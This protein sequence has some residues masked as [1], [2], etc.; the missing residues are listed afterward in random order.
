[1]TVLRDAVEAAERLAG[2]LSDHRPAIRGQLMRRRA[3]LLEARVRLL[4]AWAGAEVDVQVGSD[5]E[6]GRRIHVS[7]EPGTTSAL[8]VADHAALDDDVRIH[9]KGGR[10][11]LDP[12]AHLRPGVVLNVSGRLHVGEQ[13]LLSWGSV[14]HCAHEVHIGRRAFIGEYTTIVD[15]SH[16]F[17]S[18]DEWAY[19][20]ISVGRVEIGENTWVAAK[21]TIARDVRIGAHCI[22]SASA[23]V[24]NDVPDGHLAAGVPAKARPIELPWGGT[25]PAP[26][27]RPVQPPSSSS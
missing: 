23:V 2:R 13:A 15:S 25:G 5:V 1:M 18:P 14:V 9:L 26:S 24:L 17:T 27:D 20:N 19:G 6:L 21:A 8:V 11:D 12:G 10:V 22:V 3:Q 16:F 7:V 4:A